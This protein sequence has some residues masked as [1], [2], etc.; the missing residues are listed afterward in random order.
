MSKR[1]R[2]WKIIKPDECCNLQTEKLHY[3]G[4][5]PI[6]DME[7][8]KISITKWRI[9]RFL[10]RRKFVDDGGRLTCGFCMLHS[11]NCCSCPIFKKTERIECKET[12]YERYSYYNKSDDLD[13]MNFT[14]HQSAEDEVKFIESLRPT[15]YGER[16]QNA[17]HSQV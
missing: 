15:I 6:N 12:P 3:S 9:L 2:K 10:T 14:I 13:M 4:C 17:L 8:Y 7:A 5:E 1:E 16:K 11:Y